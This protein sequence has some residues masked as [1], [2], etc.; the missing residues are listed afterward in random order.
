MSQ[1]VARSLPEWLVAGVGLGLA[2][3]FV[4]ACV[5][6]VG[7]R[8]FPTATADRTQRVS[9]DQKRRRE[10][11]QYLRTIDEPFAEDHPVEGQSVAFYL[12]KRN[13][14]ITFD[15]RVYYRLERSSTYPVLVEHEMPGV[16]LGS[17]LPFETP[18]LDPDESGVDPASAAFAVLGLP[19]EATA[20]DVRAAYREKVKQVHPDH[21]GDHESF[22]RVREAYTTAKEHA[23]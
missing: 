14:A 7:A 2:S 17:R 20:A 15:A 18:A 10:I 16:Y 13:V 11:R 9:G 8:L 4:V 23:G 6:V 12:P 3:V 19:V 21:G 22:R 1:E 5:F